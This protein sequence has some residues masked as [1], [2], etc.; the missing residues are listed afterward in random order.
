MLYTLYMNML[1]YAPAARSGLSEIAVFSLQ[2]VSRAIMSA[3]T[4]VFFT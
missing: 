4:H 1:V 2:Q 3:S